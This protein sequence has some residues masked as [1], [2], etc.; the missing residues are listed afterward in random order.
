MTAVLSPTS[1]RRIARRWLLLALASLVLAGLFALAVVIGRTP[2]L[3]RLVTDPQF[4]KR[5]LVIHVNLALVTWFYSFLAALSLLTPSSRRAGPVARHA[6]ALATAGVTLMT[7]GALV[8]AGR[9]LLANYIPTIDNAVFQTG[10]VLFAAGI[11]ASLATRRLWRAAN[12]ATG[13]LDMPGAAHAG[14]RAIALALALAGTTLAVS[15]FGAPHVAAAARYDRLVWGIGHVLQ[16]V[17]VLGMVTVWILLLTP[18]LGTAPVSPRVA[19]A[20]FLAL[21]LPWTVAPLFALAPPWSA[22]ATVGFTAL[23]RWCLFPIVG[24]FLMLCGSAVI[25]AWRDGRLPAASLRDPRL[26]SFLV[27]A[28]LTLLGFVLG[29]AIRGSTTMVPAHY[30]AALSA[31][32]VAFMAATFVLLPVFG[33]AIPKGWTARAATWQ[34]PLYGLGM[35]V[36]AS[37]FAIAGAHGMGRKIYG[38]EQAARGLAES[39]GLALMG[40]GGLLAVTAGVLFLVVVVTAWWRGARAS[41]VAP[42]YDDISIGRNTAALAVVPAL[43]R[44][45]RRSRHEAR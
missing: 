31:V 27:S 25:R 11:L 34:P 20:L 9:P 6:V 1:D 44:T 41:R 7:A 19:G 15:A 39:V 35:L 22:A 32:T 5:C 4:F 16:L 13:A 28:A 33:I 10:Q 38:A 24:T 42:L 17:S 40:A 21:V 2:P 8:P 29:A 23:M 26:S 14:L 18:V 30:H 3:D 43:A 45:R 12:G 36:F 37:G